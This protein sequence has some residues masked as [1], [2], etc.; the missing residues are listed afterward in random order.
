MH[1]F[2]I[3]CDQPIEVAGDE[4][5]FCRVSQGAI[6]YTQEEASLLFDT[7]IPALTPEEAWLYA[8]VI[9]A[10]CLMAWGIKLALR[11][12]LNR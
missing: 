5:V 12:L 3:G 4:F 9:H 2:F 11:Q 8:G 6:Q 7:N 10:S 1:P